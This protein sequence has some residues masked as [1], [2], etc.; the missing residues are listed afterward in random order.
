M[1]HQEPG[2]NQARQDE[3]VS[4]TYLK[5]TRTVAR[6]SAKCLFCGWES[7]AYDPLYLPVIG[8]VPLATFCSSDH[9]D[10]HMRMPMMTVYG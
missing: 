1:H 8:G 7:V 3:E 4:M 2:K 5:L 6:T 10:R 9:A